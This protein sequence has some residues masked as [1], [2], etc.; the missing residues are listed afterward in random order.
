MKRELQAPTPCC[1]GL[2]ASELAVLRNGPLSETCSSTLRGALWARLRSTSSWGE[3]EAGALF[4]G[5]R[6]FLWV[7]GAH[8]P[9]KSLRALMDPL[10]DALCGAPK[11]LK[12]SVER[13][14][15]KGPMSSDS[16]L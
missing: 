9:E 15:E 11:W 7:V 1:S 13:L 2:L 8:R 5:L 16:L 6:D 14:S 12:S 4:E 3:R 10:A